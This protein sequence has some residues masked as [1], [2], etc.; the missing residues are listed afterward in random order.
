MSNMSYCRFQN[1]LADLDDC[2]DALEAMLTGGDH[3][4]L[5]REER[6]AAIR[7]VERCFQIADLFRDEGVEDDH[8][9]REG[10]IGNAIALAMAPSDDDQDDDLMPDVDDAAPDTRGVE[11]DNGHPARAQ[12]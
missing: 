5:S 11:E 1:T 10:Q 2:A 9:D 7:L 3:D 6:E 8:Y 4:E 12:D